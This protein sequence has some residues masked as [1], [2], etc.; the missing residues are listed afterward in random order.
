MTRSEN[1]LKNA[2]MA[3]KKVLFMELQQETNSFS[4][5]RT[6]L[7]DFS[8]LILLYGD[9]VEPVARRTRYQLRGFYE[10]YDRFGRADIEVVPVFSAWATSGGPLTAETWQHF[11]N[12]TENSLRQHPDAAGFYLSLHGA[13]AVEGITDAEG[14]LVFWLRER[15]GPDVPVGVSLDLHANLTCRMAST[16][17]FILA[18]H[19]NPHRDHVRLGFQAAKL[20]FETVLGQIKPVMAWRKLPMLKGGG[21]NIDFLSPTRGIFRHM[22]RL[23]A[24]PGVLA[25][26]TLMVH[27]WLDDPELGWSVVVVTDN[28]RP[29]A[30]RLADQLADLNWAVRHHRHPEPDTPES[31]LARLR[32]QR[33]RTRLG[34]AVL[35][36]ASDA[37]AAGAPGESTHLLKILSEEAPDLTTYVPLRDEAT[38]AELYEKPI[39]SAWS[40]T[41]GGRLETRFNAPLPFGGTVLSR[42]EIREA[43]PIVKETGRV[44]V[45]RRGG[46]HVVLTDRP[47]PVF[48]PSFF[49][50]LGLSLWRADAVVVKNLFP[51]RYFF[52]PYNRLTLN[53]VTPG[54]TDI[55]VF[56]LGYRQIPR[57][58]FPLDD[59]R[60][61]RS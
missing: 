12:V 32:A 39:G 21:F 31:A 8:H 17:T 61:W 1:D 35:C 55:D 26:A 4:P 22:A 11:L 45:L 47:N 27:I 34:T 24:Q 28:D 58:I 25:V 42:H 38:V 9:E 29:L 49:T 54:V 53:V 20:L 10:A 13:M 52:L 5:L 41:L 60:D 16:A 43:G 51:F 6:T 48:R 19:T 36:D 56:R 46:T 33:W 7:I 57:P 50:N 37:V 59:V 3:R 44:V 2:R 14:E 15:I 40:G 30:E 18:Y 23:E